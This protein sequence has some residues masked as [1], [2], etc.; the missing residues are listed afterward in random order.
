MSTPHRK[1]WIIRLLLLGS[2]ATA[3]FGQC[4]STCAPDAKQASGAVYRVC[5]PQPSCFNGNLVIYAHGYVDEFQPVGIPEDQLEFPDGSSVPKLIN[6]LGFAFATTSY[7]RNGLAVLEGVRDIRDL[8]NIYTARHGAPQGVYLVGPS[9]GGLVTAKSME[10]YPNIYA[11]G[12]AACGP[13]GDFRAQINYIGNFRVLLDYFFPGTIP[14]NPVD[15]PKSVINGWNTVFEPRLRQAV[16]NRPNA[17]AELIRVAGV[18]TLA[19]ADIEDAIVKVAWYSVFATND[20]RRQLGGQP[21]DNIGH[22]YLGSS[23][24]LL[25]NLF[26][27]RVAADPAAIA[28]MRQ[29]ETSGMLANPLVT[30]HTTADPIIPY[31]HEWWYRWKVESSR[32]SGLHINIPIV[33]YGHCQFNSAE[34]LISFLLVLLQVAGR[35]VP[36]TARPL[37]ADIPV[38]MSAP[39]VAPF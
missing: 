21:F 10:T 39:S 20:A 11:G 27:R 4:S 7:S 25:L 36:Q 19:P 34:A 31:W 35:P 37:S 8:V 26:V 1:P 17:A 33:R 5:M 2:A 16:R 9:E 13:V 32:S 24:D 12:V 28:A 6:G 18:S 29:Y 14:G 3:A 22:L 15:I 38:L 30:L 23:N